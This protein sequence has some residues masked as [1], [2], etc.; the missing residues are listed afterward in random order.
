MSKLSDFSRG[1]LV[2]LEACSARHLKTSRG[3]LTHTEEM[4]GIV[5]WSSYASPSVHVLLEDGAIL[6]IAYYYLQY[7]DIPRPR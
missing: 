2:I 6:K 3:F 7:L 1:D 5:L 4:W